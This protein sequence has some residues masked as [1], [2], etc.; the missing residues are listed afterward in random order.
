MD[1]ETVPIGVKNVHRRLRRDT[2]CEE[3]RSLR[4]H[5]LQSDKDL[6]PDRIDFGFSALDVR[7]SFCDGSILLFTWAFDG[8]EDVEFPLHEH[9]GVHE[10]T[11]LTT[12]GLLV[13]E[14]TQGVRKTLRR[15][16][17][18]F[19][20]DPGVAHRLL[21]SAEGGPAKGWTAFQPPD[22]DLV[23]T[24]MDG[25]CSLRPLGRC[26]GDPRKCM[27]SRVRALMQQSAKQT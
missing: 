6:Q 14:T 18:S 11:A 22:M 25:N 8:S 15:P 12:T 16:G 9:V 20:A 19:Y 3:M 10:H 17:D 7:A 1:R 4:D 13:F 26:G 21:L 5:L 24:D 2:L 23:P 27:H